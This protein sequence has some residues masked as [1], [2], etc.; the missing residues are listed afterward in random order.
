[1]VKH[2]YPP[3]MPPSLLILLGQHQHPTMFSD[4]V[5]RL[6]LAQTL[7]IDTSDQAIVAMQRSN[8]EV[9]DRR[10]GVMRLW[11]EDVTP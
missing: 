8:Q 10:A 2:S 6:V 1:M 3:T 9:A 7:P 11:L 4:T 5:M